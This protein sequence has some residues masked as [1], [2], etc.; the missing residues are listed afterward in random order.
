MTTPESITGAPEPT[1]P[2]HTAPPVAESPGPGL[3]APPSP[4][5][6]APAAGDGIDRFFAAMR[7]FGVV[8]RSDDR[9]VAGVSSGLAARLGVDPL[10]IRAAFVGLSI[11]GGVGVTAYLAA[12]ALLPDTDGRIRAESAIRHGDG[13]GIVLLVLLALALFPGQ[14]FWWRAPLTLVV[15]AGIIWVVMSGRQRSMPISAQTGAPTTG[16]AYPPPPPAAGPWAGAGSAAAAPGMGGAT[17][18]PTR[19][20]APPPP[21]PRPRRPGGFSVTVLGIGL[22]VLAYVAGSTLAERGDWSQGSPAFFG[23]LWALVTVG[24]LALIVGLRGWRAPLLVLVTIVIAI[25]AAVAAAV[26]T[27]PWQGGFGDRTWLPTTSLESSYELGAGDVV[28]DLRKMPTSALAGQATTVKLG[29][30]QVTVLPP[31]DV[32]VVMQTQ[33]GLGNLRVKDA[34]GRTI[35]NRDGAGIDDTVDI[36][37]GA[38]TM[39]LDVQVGLGEVTVKE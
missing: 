24:A 18:P 20:V 35:L 12:W 32:H 4:P 8:R 6:A 10:I 16:A 39:H 9:W 31:Q 33:I 11:L 7:G 36:G 30:G 17:P 13:G 2:E 37:S 38:T 26:P 29:V 5:P 15:V 25:Q 27:V 28:L 22:S 34:S 19:Y 3:G 23:S 1:A 14:Q 21:A